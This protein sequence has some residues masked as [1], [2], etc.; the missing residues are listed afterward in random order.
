MPHFFIYAGENMNKVQSQEVKQSKNSQ[1]SAKPAPNQSTLK[2]QVA[3]LTAQVGELKTQLAQVRGAETSS[4]TS[5]SNDS[6]VSNLEGQR[7]GNAYNAEISKGVRERKIQDQLH[8]T[9]DKLADKQTE[10]G[11]NTSVS[12]V[13]GSGNTGIGDSNN[14]DNSKNSTPNNE[15]DK[16][17]SKAETARAL[18]TLAPGGH[19][20]NQHELIG[21]LKAS[22]G[23]MAEVKPGDNSMVS[24]FKGEAN[25]NEDAVSNRNCGRCALLSTARAMGMGG[26]AS[27]ANSDLEKVGSL[28][29]QNGKNE[30]QGTQIND[31]LTGAKNMGM[32]AKAGKGGI[33]QIKQQLASGNQVVIATDPSKYTGFTKKGGHMVR[34]S[35]YDEKK[36]TFTLHDSLFQKPIEVQAKQLGKAMSSDLLGQNKNTMIIIDKNS[37]LDK[38]ALNKV[39]EQQKTSPGLA[40]N[41]S[42]QKAEDKGPVKGSAGNEPSKIDNT[43]KA[44]VDEND[45]A[46]NKKEKPKSPGD[47]YPG[48]GYENHWTYD[49]KTSEV[50]P[51][52]KNKS[53]SPAGFSKKD[54]SIQEQKSKQVIGHLTSST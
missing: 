15:G 42:E 32:N 12:D 22:G 16:G 7:S 4:E 51:L 52:D 19:D 49:P 37:K 34:V 50:I 26:D 13:T 3:S 40:S 8:L 9:A 38:G 31:F 23:N 25:I 47:I 35:G 44:K 18:N 46:G 6:R 36:D 41:N 33:E 20:P 30:Y 17:I 2:A 53:Q 54:D 43:S 28:M 48:S 1:S 39:P 27:T 24:Q 29:G 14:K 21:G 10:S 5:S 45:G 11:R